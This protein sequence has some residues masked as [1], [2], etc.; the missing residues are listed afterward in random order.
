MEPVTTLV[1]INL[2]LTAITPIITAVG[3]AITHI[4]RSKCCGGEVLMRDQSIKVN[5]I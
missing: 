1:V 2:V 4:K 3:F 5:K